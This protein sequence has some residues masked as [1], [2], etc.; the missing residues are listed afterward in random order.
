MNHELIAEKIPPVSVLSYLSASCPNYWEII[1]QFAT[2]GNSYM[3]WILQL[4]LSSTEVTKP[5]GPLKEDLGVVVYICI[6]KRIH[7][8]RKH[9]SCNVAINQLH[10]ISPV[11]RSRVS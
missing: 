7:H 6:I 9:T 4:L 11:F 2:E 10:T 3:F 5:S 1:S 8:Q